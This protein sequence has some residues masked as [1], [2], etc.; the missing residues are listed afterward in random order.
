MCFALALWLLNC[1]L[2]EF[3]Y[4]CC[5]AVSRWEIVAVSRSKRAG[6]EL[7]TEMQEHL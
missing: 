7:A 5:S 1:R 4:V 6:N 2:Y 3:A